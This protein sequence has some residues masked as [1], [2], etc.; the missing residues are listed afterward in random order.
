MTTREREGVVAVVGATGVVGR[1]MLRILE[2]RGFAAGRVRALASP[3]S[4]GRSLPYG[5]GTL[6]VE[7]A[8]PEAFEGVSLALFSAGAAAS[9]ELAPEAAKR[10]CTVID[11]S[12]AWRM[13]PDV[14]LVIPEVNPDALASIPKGIVA[15]PNC[16]TIQLLV[17]LAPLHR[18]ARLVHVFVAT[19]QAASGK[20][21]AA[22]EDLLA[23]ER[24]L[25]AGEAVS[26]TV[27]PGQLA[28]NVLMD[29]KA[30]S[31]PDAD[32]SEEELKMIHETRKILG[33]SSIGVSPT[34]VRV[35]VVTGHSEAVVARFSRPMSAAEAVTLLEGAPGVLLHHGPYA[36]GKHP[37]PALVE[38]RDAVHV[39]RVRD[40][41]GAPG[42]LALFV[43]GDNL[44]KGAALNA[45]Q[46]AE[47]L[48]RRASA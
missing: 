43:V 15:N 4:V 9:R 42:S 2:E 28:R 45:I 38:G 33:D 37:Q 10:G 46:I 12:S 41:R 3:R 31:G 36:P 26:P 44:R 18:A 47:E 5:G 29:W 7:E 30:A 1:E 17:A 8:R 14:P 22:V 6:Q 40:D 32:W 25:A 13:D 34:T 39:G 35:P 48:E 19:Y 16:S 23:Q 27:L 21:H 20:G 24:A 11:N